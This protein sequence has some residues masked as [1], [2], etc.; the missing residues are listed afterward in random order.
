MKLRK[1]FHSNG[2]NYPDHMEAE[3][4]VG[5]DNIDAEDYVQNMLVNSFTQ[6]NPVI[7]YFLSCYA[8]SQNLRL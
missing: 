4:M 6:N 8:V 2:S 3:V 5:S 1:T 7:F